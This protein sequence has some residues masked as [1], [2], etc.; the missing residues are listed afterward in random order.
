MFMNK[1]SLSKW[2]LLHRC[3]RFA[4]T[5]KNKHQ[6]ELQIFSL[7]C[8]FKIHFLFTLKQLIFYIERQFDVSYKS[9]FSEPVE[10]PYKKETLV[11][12]LHTKI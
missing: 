2:I 12:T 1:L 6:F 8:F 4:L 3:C 7:F 9:L 5:R 11:S 10:P